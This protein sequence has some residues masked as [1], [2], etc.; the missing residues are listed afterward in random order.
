MDPQQIDRQRVDTLTES[1]DQISGSNDKLI[2]LK[3]DDSLVLAPPRLLPFQS[4]GGVVAPGT[5]DPTGVALNT[6]AHAR[7]QIPATANI[8]VGSRANYFTATT[9][10]TPVTYDVPRFEGDGV[11]N[12]ME[13]SVVGNKGRITFKSKG[14]FSANIQLDFMIK[15]A[16]IRAGSGGELVAHMDLYS[17]D[18]TKKNEFMAATEE[19][20]DS[21]TSQEAWTDGRAIGLTPVELDDY[22]EFRL[23][24]I[25]SHLSDVISV[26]IPAHSTTSPAHIDLSFY[27]NSPPVNVLGDLSFTPIARIDVEDKPAETD[28]ADAPIAAY[29]QKSS[30]SNWEV[31]EHSH[32]STL[33]GNT[34]IRDMFGR[35]SN[36]GVFKITGTGQRCQC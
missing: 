28:I 10:N 15:G 1:G 11:T 9:L 7:F 2:I 18:G 13:A 36:P 30:S 6:G 25:A 21:I 20:N 23:D 17:K 24:W 4:G 29:I 16:T 34:W 35:Q 19:F 27:S 26:A 33:D 22:L 14:N 32:A 12:V 3:P 31:G 5:P 8:T